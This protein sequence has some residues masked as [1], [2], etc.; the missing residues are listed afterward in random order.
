MPSSLCSILARFFTRQQVLIS[1]LLSR[2]RVPSWLP[3]LSCHVQQLVVGAITADRAAGV[4]GSRADSPPPV[5]HSPS[6]I[7]VSVFLLLVVS[8][9]FCPCSCFM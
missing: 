9:L 6:P 8:R 7:Y 5:A 2:F 3:L 4:H 1:C